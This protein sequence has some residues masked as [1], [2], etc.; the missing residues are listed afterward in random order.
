MPDDLPSPS[1]AA[2]QRHLGRR[3]PLLKALIARV[4]PCTLRPDPDGFR[5]LVQS[6][7]SQMISTKAAVTIAARLAALA[8]GGLTPAALVALGE[9]DLRGV[10]LSGSKVRALREL[11]GLPQLVRP[12][13]NGLWALS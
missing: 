10:G 9:A 13:K 6:I 11:A 1:Y 4:G 8:P 7:V 3:D 2:A 12:P 5:V